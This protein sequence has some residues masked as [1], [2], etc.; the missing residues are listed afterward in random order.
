M[1][2]YTLLFEDFPLHYNNSISKDNF[3]NRRTYYS[4]IDKLMKFDKLYTFELAC[5]SI[6][7]LKKK[8]IYNHALFKFIRNNEYSFDVYGM[9]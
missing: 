8:S 1:S 9:L 4:K 7:I 3:D 2:M 6:P 5:I